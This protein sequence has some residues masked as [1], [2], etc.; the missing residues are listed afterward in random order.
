MSNFIRT[1]QLINLDNKYVLI[2]RFKNQTFYYGRHKDQRRST[3]PTSRWTNAKHAILFNSLEDATKRCQELNAL[4][5]KLK[6]KVDKAS[7]HFVSNFIV[8]TDYWIENLYVENRYLSI[9]D[10]TDQKIKNKPC[11][12]VQPDRIKICEDKFL[13][14]RRQIHEYLRNIDST[15]QDQIENLKQV[16]AQEYARKQAELAKLDSMQNYIDEEIKTD[17]LISK[18]RTESDTKF[19]ILYG[20]AK[21]VNS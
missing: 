17:K 10:V 21:N 11:L 1:E 6:Y 12:Y 7:A 14:K 8:T 9:Q 5:Q 2:K 18:Y 4:R 13:Q 16:H 19:Q 15:L 20:D 3:R